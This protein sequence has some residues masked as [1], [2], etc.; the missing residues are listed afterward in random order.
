M[1]ELHRLHFDVVCRTESME[2]PPAPVRGA[3]GRRAGCR[4]VTRGNKFQTRRCALVR[5]A[6]QCPRTPRPP[7][8]RG[9]GPLCTGIATPT[10]PGVEGARC[11]LQGAHTERSSRER[12]VA[13]RLGAGLRVSAE[14]CGRCRP[15]SASSPS[16]NIAAPSCADCSP[17]PPL[18][19]P[20]PAPPHPLLVLVSCYARARRAGRGNGRGDYVRHQPLGGR[21]RG[22]SPGASASALAVARAFAGP[23]G[24]A[25]LLRELRQI[26][27]LLRGQLARG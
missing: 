8:C 17:V 9:E 20:P 25:N 21:T 26:R 24:A 16:A 18:R 23:P 15:S 19:A 6:R 10:P 3:C 27:A 22:R 12:S 11:G 2:D 5:A 4:R 14:H 13:V 1:H 7:L